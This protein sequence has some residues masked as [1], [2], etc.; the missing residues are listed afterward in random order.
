MGFLSAKKENRVRALGWKPEA[1]PWEMVP[2]PGKD[3][4]QSRGKQA[5]R[6][7]RQS[8]SVTILPNSTL[9]ANGFENLPSWQC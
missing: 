7:S 1:L 5:L 8:S 4:D 2:L 3:P 9:A 6:K